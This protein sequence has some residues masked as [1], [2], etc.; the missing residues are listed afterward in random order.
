[1]TS[2]IAS[3]AVD[4][5]HHFADGTPM[6]C[7]HWTDLDG[8]DTYSRGG[9]EVSSQ[10]LTREQLGEQL[11]AILEGFGEHVGG[12]L[13]QGVNP[14]TLPHMVMLAGQSALEEKITVHN[15][16]WML[17]FGERNW[18]VIDELVVTGHDYFEDNTYRVVP[19]PGRCSLTPHRQPETEALVAKLNGA[20]K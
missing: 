18:H 2:T 11:G 9:R 16:T 15:V 1:M 6:A 7:H 13:M 12:V 3:P 17:S 4:R 10:D 19:I 14:P 8:W 20:A 5:Q